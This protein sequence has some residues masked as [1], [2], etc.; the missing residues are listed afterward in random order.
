MLSAKDELAHVV[1][2]MTEAEAEILLDIAGD[3]DENA[4]KVT[5]AVELL[6][7]AARL[8]YQ[9]GRP[10]CVKAGE[11]VDA[12]LKDLLALGAEKMLRERLTEIL[13]NFARSLIAIIHGDAKKTDQ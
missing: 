9:D 2:G 10:E 8:L 5:T 7:I 11:H 13:R 6:K 1:A 3:A 4:D 12:V